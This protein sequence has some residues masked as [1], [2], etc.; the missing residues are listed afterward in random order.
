MRWREGPWRL[1]V[2]DGPYASAGA[3]VEDALGPL[4]LGT[5]TQRALEGE[6]PEVVLQV[7][8]G[9]GHVRSEKSPTEEGEIKKTG[10]RAIPSRSLS[11][12]S[13]G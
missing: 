12:S 11:A 5:E 6:N 9:H 4:F 1:A 2:F 10:E 7:C 8:S 3:D 13:L